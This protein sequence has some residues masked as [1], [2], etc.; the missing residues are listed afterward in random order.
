[1]SND[2]LPCRGCASPTRSPLYCRQRCIGQSSIDSFASLQAPISGST[3]TY[4]RGLTMGRKGKPHDKRL[5][6]WSSNLSS[7]SQCSS[8]ITSNLQGC[9][10]NI[11]DCANL[12]SIKG[13]LYFWC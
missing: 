5:V 7:E 6:P 10:G 12:V 8:S 11:Y 3:T 4:V 13:Q 9:A 1:M 2:P